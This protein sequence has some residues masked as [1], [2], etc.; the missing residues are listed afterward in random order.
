MVQTE[1]TPDH[2]GAASEGHL[3]L[4]CRVNKAILTM[5]PDTQPTVVVVECKA[6]F[7]AEEDLSSLLTIPLH[8]I[9][10]EYVAFRSVQASGMVVLLGD[11]NGGS[12]HTG[13]S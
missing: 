6:R 2:D 7:V 10:A 1:D 3:F 8:M 4:N 11:G 13:G 12:Q 9:P 5:S